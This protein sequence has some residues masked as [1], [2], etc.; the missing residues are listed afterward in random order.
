MLQ[1]IVVGPGVEVTEASLA[2][3]KGQMQPVWEEQSL[4]KRDRV[5]RRPTIYAVPMTDTAKEVD[6]AIVRYKVILK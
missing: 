2:L 5:V 6:R 3:A 4:T 1:R